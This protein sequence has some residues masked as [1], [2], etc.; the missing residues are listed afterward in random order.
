MCYFW[1]D[2]V[3]EDLVGGEMFGVVGDFMYCCVG[4]WYVVVEKV[5]G[6]YDWVCG[7]EFV[8]DWERVVGLLWVG[9]VEIV[10]LVGYGWMGGRLEGVGYGGNFLIGGCWRLGVGCCYFLIILIVI[11]G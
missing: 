7:V 3:Y 6:M 4:G 9:V 8:L 1:L 5:F 11:F 2:V 10:D